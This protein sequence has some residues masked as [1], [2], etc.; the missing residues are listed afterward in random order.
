M[1]VR[2]QAG[3]RVVYGRL[4]ADAG[5]AVW[6]DAPWQGG[7]ETEEC[8][9]PGTYQLLA[10]TVPSKIVAVGR[11]YADHAAEVQATVP[12][13]P[14]IFLKPPTAVLPPGGDIVYPAQ[15][16]RVDYEGELA[17]VIGQTARHLTPTAAVAAIWG[18]TIANDVT[19][20][21]LQKQDGQWTRSKGFD[22]FCPL[23]P[24]IVRELSL[25][26]E[27]ETWLNGERKQV[28]K[29]QEM[30]FKPPVLV[31]YISQVMTLL[32]GDVVLTGTPAGIGPMQPGDEIQVHI[33]GIG[34]LRNRVVAQPRL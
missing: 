18:Y 2:A 34:T 11:N 28:A 22:T 29:L 27:L 12:V 21:D 14:V 33:T 6:T 10:P 25:E 23:G 15:S 17:L 7:T 13:E 3:A 32:P 5:L 26:M 30:V 4:T 9:A 24:G 19:A 20:R 1:W 8:W 16:R 31:S